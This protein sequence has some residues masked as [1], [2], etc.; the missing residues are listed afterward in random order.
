MEARRY[1]E[2]GL[3]LLR[4]VGDRAAESNAL[5]EFSVLE[6]WEGNAALAQAH[7]QSA[8]EIAVAAQNREIECFV[9]LQLGDAE[10][11]LERHAAAQ[12]AFARSHAVALS[13]DHLYKYDAVAGL[14]RVALAQ[15]DVAGALLLLKGLLNHLAAGGTLVGTASRNRS[16][17][18]CH[19][20]L[21]C[22]GDLRAAEV[23]AIGH[24]ELQAR[25]SSITDA[26]LRRCFLTNVPENREIVAAWTA[27]Q[28]ASASEH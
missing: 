8:L 13:I 9:L 23:L 12:T 28:A 27:Q 10:L 24:S 6:L 26:S 3:Q 1:L 19:Q 18:S 15:G 20:V 21:I 2:E 5:A 11:A 16:S 25:A 7:A 17:W 22:A 14:A 4:A